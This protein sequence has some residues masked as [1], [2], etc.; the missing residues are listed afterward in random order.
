LLKKSNEEFIQMN[1]EFKK[2]NDIIVSERKLFDNEL[3]LCD[4][5]N[6]DAINYISNLEDN[7]DKVVNAK[8]AEL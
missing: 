2:E 6:S 1:L 4:K 7:L 8:E 5:N 3:K